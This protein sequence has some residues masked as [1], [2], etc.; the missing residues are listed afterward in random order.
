MSQIAL[1]LCKFCCNIYRGSNII[2]ISYIKE[3][4]PKNI[5]MSYTYLSKSLRSQHWSLEFIFSLLCLKSS[6]LR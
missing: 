5:S 3:N 2:S 4:K 1:N 6:I